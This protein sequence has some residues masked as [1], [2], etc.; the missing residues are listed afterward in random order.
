VT[1]LKSRQTAS[2]IAVL[3]FVFKYKSSKSHLCK[4][5]FANA[6]LVTRRVKAY[7]IKKSQKNRGASG[8][9]TRKAPGVSTA[10]TLLGNSLTRVWLFGLEFKKRLAFGVLKILAIGDEDFSRHP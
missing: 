10:Q 8:S 4:I 3:W 1:S 7:G 9:V 5:R 2:Y 6:R